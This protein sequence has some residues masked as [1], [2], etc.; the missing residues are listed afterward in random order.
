M[1]EGDDL[2]QGWL[3]CQKSHEPQ[4]CELA[5]SGQWGTRVVWG[6]SSTPVTSVGGMSWGRSGKSHRCEGQL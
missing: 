3:H 1:S 6:L 4:R 2:R 5:F